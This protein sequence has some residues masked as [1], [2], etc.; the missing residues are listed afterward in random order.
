MWRVKQKNSCVRGYPMPTGWRGF[1][2]PENTAPPTRYHQ[3]NGI[4]KWKLEKGEEKNPTHRFGACGTRRCTSLCGQRKPRP[5]NENDVSVLGRVL[6]KIVVR[7]Y[8]QV[9]EML[10]GSVGEKSVK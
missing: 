7:K 1:S 10:N 2:S 3:Q 4:K 9:T 6:A 8:C 5:Y